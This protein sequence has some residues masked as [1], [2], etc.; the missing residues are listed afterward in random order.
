MSPKQMQ[1]MTRLLWAAA[2]M[3]TL[4]VTHGQN[5]PVRLAESWQ[6]GAYT[7]SDATG[8]H[9]IALWTFDAGS[10]LKAEG[11]RSFDITL[12]GAKLNATGRFGG[13]LE[14]FRGHPVE[15][16]N[17][18]AKIANHRELSPKGAFTI[19][20]WIKPK[21]ELKDYPSCF[22]LDKKYVSHTDYQL[23]LGP[24]G[25]RSTKRALRAV[26]GYG[27]DSAWYSSDPLVYEP[28]VWY[29]VAFTY[30]GAGKGQFWR[31]GKAMGGTTRAGREA[32]AP[33]KRFLTIGDRNGSLY[34]GFPGFIDQVRICDGVLEFRPAA[35]AMESAR[36]TFV[37]MEKEVALRFS[38]TNRMRRP[39]EGA[40]CR[41][42]MIGASDHRVTVPDLAQG[43][44]HQIEYALDTSLS[45]GPYDVV[46]RIELPGTPPYVSDERFPITIVPRPL[47]HRMPVVMWGVGGTDTVVEE[48]DTLRD[49]GFTHCLGG[50]A[51]MRKIWDAGEPTQASDDGRVAN[52]Q[53][54]L[55]TALAKGLRVMMG[56]TP[57]RWARTK[58]EFLRVGQDGKHLEDIDGLHPEV[59]TFCYNVGASVAQTY[60]DFPGL[61]G[62]M[63]H[64]EVRGASAPSFSDVDKAAFLKHA[65]YGIPEGVDTKYG[66]RYTTLNEFPTDR[67]IP[68]DFPLYVYYRWLWGQG[69][70][71][72]ALHTA[73]NRGLKTGVHEHFWTFHD[74]AVR[75]ASV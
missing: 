8:K 37:R 19:E 59:Q 73:L 21:S 7:G 31:D 25:K 41:I 17:H 58:K 74:P 69:D 3:C 36:T 63:V 71:W 14:S 23:V 33:G 68:D 39:L 66:T 60:G 20:M 70:G 16:V 62:V 11:D 55:N 56:L 10:E 22:L 32:V 34:H 35:L 67:V 65:G 50:T 5:Q 53:A 72:S 13:C 47:P 6:S 64:T 26:L 38:V 2:W 54:M 42:G 12:M 46:A 52:T 28:G 61:D 44:G 4:C 29:H 24:S 30:D 51:D 9:V 15:D 43:A 18:G 27:D 1:N 40:I 57:G 45:P 75:V 49:L 48:I